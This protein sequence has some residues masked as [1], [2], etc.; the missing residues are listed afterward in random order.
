MRIGRSPSD[1]RTRVVIVTAD[2][3]FERAARETFG[4]SSAIDLAVVSGRL[5]ERCDKLPLDG[6]TVVVVDF[7][8][9]QADEMAAM[10]G[11][12]ARI[13]NWPPVIAITQSLR[14]G[15]RAHAAADAHRR[16]P[17]EAGGAGRSGARLRPG[18]QGP[19]RGQ[20]ADRRADLHLPAGGR[21][22]RRH[23][24]RGADR[25]A[26]A[27][28]RRP[29]QQAVD[30]S[31]RSRLPARRR[32]RLSRSRA[33]PESRGNRAASRP[34]RPAAPGD[35]AVLSRL[36]SGGGGG[37]QPA[38]RDA[39]VR[40]RRGDAPARSRLRQFPIRRVRHAAHLVL[41]DRQRA[42]RLQQAVH[43]QPRPRC[44]ACATP[45]NW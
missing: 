19:V 18:R 7:D 37:A 24:A 1:N 39:L 13:G 26:A 29:A 35:H 41:L 45:S 40:S 20:R 21:R 17:G 44:R 36:R 9:S 6:A 23:H 8:A 14:R 22:G 33:A 11:L 15:R 4:A 25:D 5:A 42:A 32:R 12:M 16:L 38:G 34:P 28:Q 30:L 3:E 2:E 27:Q 10:S 43:R 31:G